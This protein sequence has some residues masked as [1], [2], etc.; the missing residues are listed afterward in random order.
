M[1]ILKAPYNIFFYQT[2]NLKKSPK[3][4]QV[5]WQVGASLQGASKKKPKKTPQS[6][7]V[8][9]RGIAIFWPIS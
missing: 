9:L 3:K 7:S 1:E 5:P 8:A 2:K 6:R 4:R